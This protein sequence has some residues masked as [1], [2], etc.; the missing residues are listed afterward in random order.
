[1]K[2]SAKVGQFELFAVV[3]VNHVGFAA[4]NGDLRLRIFRP[5]VEFAISKPPIGEQHQVTVFLSVISS[6]VD[7][8]V[9]THIGVE[10]Q[11]LA[12]TV[13]KLPPANK[14]GRFVVRQGG[15]RNDNREKTAEIMVR[16]S[17]TAIGTMRYYR[18]KNPEIGSLFVA[19][20][21]RRPA[22]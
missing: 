13:V 3:V 9:L 18:S 5:A 12:G 17:S 11:V 15:R 7:D 4:D 22:G 14:T 19:R 1:M 2:S 6:D 20:V 10:I 8:Q 21:L 16:I